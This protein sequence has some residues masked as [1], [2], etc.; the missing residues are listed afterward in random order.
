MTRHV[1]LFNLMWR[2]AMKN[3]ALLSL[4]LTLGLL[5]VAGCNL[6]QNAALEAGVSPAPVSP[7]PRVAKVSREIILVPLGD[8]PESKVQAL[9]KYYRDKFNLNVKTVPPLAIKPSAFDK[10]RKQL[11]AEQA[12]EDMQWGYP[13]L[14]GDPRAVMIGL[15]NV[16]MFIRKYDWRFTFSWRQ[17]GRFAVVSDARMSLGSPRPSQ[18]KIESRLRKMVTKDI[19][20]MYYDR[21]PSD[22]PRSVMYDRIGGLKEL[23]FMGEDF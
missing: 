10:R 13:R 9:V 12:L 4:S 5:L 16:D 20:I 17:Y 7:A 2:Y 15:T 6:G 21:Q 1:Y 19:G 8:F 18:D 3:R 22:D 14:S 23:D 11:I